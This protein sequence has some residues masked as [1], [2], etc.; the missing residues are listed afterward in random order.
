VAKNRN[1]ETGIV[2]LTR[3]GE[4]ARVTSPGWSPSR[5]ASP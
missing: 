1:G 5:H 2:T 4:Y 3:Q